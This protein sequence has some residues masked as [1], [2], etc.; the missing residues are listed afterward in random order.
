MKK[1]MLRKLRAQAE[2]VLGKEET[3]KIINETVSEVLKDT[4]PKTK[5]KKKKVE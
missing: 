1:A 3:E 2:E 4:K 5:T